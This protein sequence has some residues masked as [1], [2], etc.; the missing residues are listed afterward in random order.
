MKKNYEAPKAEVV[1]FAKKDV[2]TSSGFI[3]DWNLPEIDLGGDGWIW[4]EN[5]GIFRL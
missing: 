1:S 5:G 3:F 2:V 4:D